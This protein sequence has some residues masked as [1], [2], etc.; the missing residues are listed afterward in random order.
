MTQEKAGVVLVADDNE[1]MLKM[2]A[3]MLTAEGYVVRAVSNGED[4]VQALERES[5]DLVLSDIDMPGRNGLELLQAIRARDLDVP[6]ILLTGGPTI[7]SAIAAVE[8]GASHYLTKP[9]NWPLLK[10]T[11]HRSMHAG[12]LARAR[13]DLVQLASNDA[14]Q[15]ADL[16]GLSARFDKALSTLFMLWQP[17][18]RWSDQ[19]LFAY[20]AVVRSAEPALPSPGALFDAADRLQ[21]T[22]DIGQRIRSLCGETRGADSGVL[23]FVNV[24]PLDLMD[25]AL[26]DPNAPLS[27]IAQG[28]VLEITERA[29]LEVVLELPE[30][31]ARLRDLGY[32]IAIDDLGAGYAGLTSF[33]ALEPEFM[34]LDRGLVRDIHSSPTKLRLVGAMVR[35]CLDLGVQVVGEGV[36]QIDERDALIG[37]GC[38]LFQG[39][40][41]GKPEPPFAALRP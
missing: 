2:L 31:I 23:F 15:I 33:A 9:V 4:A 35:A 38:D 17:I 28:V 36:E 27:R 7:E 12:R 25:D 24:L 41:I 26:Y 3:R 11:I 6:V 16:A 14:F 5:V 22:D 8:Y 19:S 39:Y 21:R 10:Q 40:L 37:L 29:R 13:R 1:A 30:R 20:E 18:V 32:R 34:K